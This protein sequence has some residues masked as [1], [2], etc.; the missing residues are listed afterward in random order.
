MCGRYALHSNPDVV[1][2]QFHLAAVPAFT[3]RYNI[4][5]SEPILAVRAK[6]SGAREAV[7]LRWGLVRR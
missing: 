5:P 2:L 6:P 1:A 3:P 4:A 7:I